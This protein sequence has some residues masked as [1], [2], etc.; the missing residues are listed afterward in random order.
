MLCSAWGLGCAPI[1]LH[2]SSNQAQQQGVQDAEHW[3]Q[4]HS[5]SS[6]QVPICLQQL[7]CGLMRTLRYATLLWC[8][9]H[10]W[11]HPAHV[12][13]Q[14]LALQ[15][16]QIGM[17]RSR[18]AELE[19]RSAALREQVA[20]QRKARGGVNAAHEST[21]AVSSSRCLQGVALGEA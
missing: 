17:E 3:C 21:I 14:G 4:Q 8:R 1:G 9:C 16:V 18:V 19:E 12:G 2:V 10:A 11:L 7:R 6:R 13:P 15:W 5:C 20:G